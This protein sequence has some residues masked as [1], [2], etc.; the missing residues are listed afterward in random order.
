MVAAKTPPEARRIPA[1]MSQSVPVP[2]RPASPVLGGR[3]RPAVGICAIEI[4]ATGAGGGVGAQLIDTVVLPAT[5]PEV[6]VTVAVWLLVTLAVT[7]VVATPPVVE[8]LEAP[9]PVPEKLTSVPFGTALPNWSRT[10][11]V[12]VDVPVQLRIGVAVTATVAGTQPKF[13]KPPTPNVLNPPTLV[14]PPRLVK[15]P[16]QLL[17]QP[18]VAKVVQGL[19]P[20]LPKFPNVPK[21]PKVP[22]PSR[23]QG[24]QPSVPKL[25]KVSKAQGLHPS[26]PRVV[27]RPKHGLTPALH[28]TGV[29]EAEVPP[30]VMV[31]KTL[32]VV[33]HVTVNDTVTVSASVSRSSAIVQDV[34][35]EVK[36]AV[37]AAPPGVSEALHAV[38]VPPVIVR[39]AD[40]PI[41]ESGSVK[42]AVPLPGAA[43]KLTEPAVALTLVECRL[44]APKRPIAV[45]SASSTPILNR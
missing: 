28:R 1:H 25:P 36:D 9:T 35:P 15:L 21:L 13:P 32:V 6:A 41:V 14:N 33:A 30:W 20:T 19:Q 26:V 11:A 10:V 22:K 2:A 4:G 16:R 23:A 12:T 17:A 8:P 42:V 45:A 29:D 7:V 44:R 5:P 43:S 24:L 38:S 40:P 27:P 37:L 34:V 39:T 18:T 3:T 31:A